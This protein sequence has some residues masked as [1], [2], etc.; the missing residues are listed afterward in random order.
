MKRS[1]ILALGLTLVGCAI[2][3]WKPPI[4]TTCQATGCP[5]GFECKEWGQCV[6]KPSPSPESSPSPLP[7]A[8]PSPSPTPVPSPTPIPAPTPVPSPL[9]CLASP[10]CNKPPNC[11]SCAA[12]MADAI[13]SGELIREGRLVY[14][15]GNAGKEYFDPETC[16]TV[17][18]DGSLRNKRLHKDGTICPVCPAPV[19]VPCASPTP[20]PSPNP[21]PRPS[22]WAFPETESGNISIADL[23]SL[24]RTGF[25]PTHEI[26]IAVLSQRDCAGESDCRVVN[27]HATEKSVKPFCEHS[28]LDEQGRYSLS[29]CRN[30]CETLRECQQPEFVSSNGGVKLEIKHPDWNNTWGDCDK[31]TAD[32]DLPDCRRNFICHDR[33]MGRQGKTEAR[34]CMPDGTR[35]GP[36]KEY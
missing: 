15:I 33:V 18:P 8:S 28:C 30:T 36:V 7:E 13:R 32:C 22:P 2:L 16:F 23:I 11:V 17:W 12:Y 3:D 26:G 21:S 10:L 25:S 5:E 27:L 1:V 34:A 20:R 31:R 35:C 14:N 24:C 29:N 19:P 6:P 4:P 9:P